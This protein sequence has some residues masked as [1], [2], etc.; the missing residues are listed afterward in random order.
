M[1]DLKVS[2]GRIVLPG[3]GVFAADVG[4]RDGKIVAMGEDLGPAH[5]EVDARGK[6][7]FPGV[8]DPHIHFGNQRAPE[9][10]MESE[11]AAALAGGV[12]TVGVFVRSMEPYSPQLPRMI[13][14][15]NARGYV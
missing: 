4:V 5:A 12:T 14:D 13:A 9:L 10:D 1:L 2:G 3:Q 7:V 6:V 8:V 11:T 15:Y